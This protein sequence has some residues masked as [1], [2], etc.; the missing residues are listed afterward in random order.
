[1]QDNAKI[2]STVTSTSDP[3]MKLKKFSLKNKLH[4]E[5]S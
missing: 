4:A 3:S 1:M 2:P 5:V